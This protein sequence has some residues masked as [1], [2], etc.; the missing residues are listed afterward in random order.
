M[1]QGR[2]ASRM[3]KEQEQWED[4]RGW[5]EQRMRLLQSILCW[6]VLSRFG[7]VSLFAI[8]WPIA[9]HALL[10]TGFSRQRYWSGL[11]CSPPGAL[12]D[13]GIKPVSL[14]SPTLVGGF[15]TSNT[16][17]E[18]HKVLCTLVNVKGWITVS[19]RKVKVMFS[20]ICP[21]SPYPPASDMCNDSVSVK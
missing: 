13:P 5:G 7:H 19:T 2:G 1:W 18:A 6:A 21:C 9:H 10:F 8:L 12:P 15:F 4:F 17:W 16:T 3:G 14:T 11:P 20:W